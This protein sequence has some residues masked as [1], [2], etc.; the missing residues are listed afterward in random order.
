MYRVVAF[1]FVFLINPLYAEEAISF[2]KELVASSSWLPYGSILIVLVIT[3]LVLAK[4]SKKIIHNNA[5]CQVIE[6]IS[7]HNKTK[8]Y[9]IAYQEQKFLVADNQNSLAIHALRT[10]SSE[11]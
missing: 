3:L 5:Q 7:V 6:K 11:S 1:L 4:H 10:T 8:V 2:K 9:V